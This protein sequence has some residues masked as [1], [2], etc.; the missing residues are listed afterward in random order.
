MKLIC[1][2]YAGAHVNVF[3]DLQRNLAE[4]HLE[5]EVLSLEYAGHGKRFSKKAFNSIHHNVSDLF[6]QLCQTIDKSEE[7]VLLGYSMGSIIAYE[8]AQLLMEQ[9]FN[10]K[11]LVFMAATPPHKI[12]VL[13]EDISEDE[14]LLQ[15][16]QIYGLIKGNQFESKEMRALFLPALRSDIQSVNDYNLVNDYQYITFDSS[17]DIA[18]FQGKEDISVTSL[19][20]WS[21]LSEKDITLYIYPS[22]HFF[23]Y[24][25]QQDVLN[26]LV[27]FITNNQECAISH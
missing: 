19:S 5:V 3:A 1:F 9:G 20:Y 16:C 22:G 24:D 11:K 10:V 14:A 18:V 8:M 27:C 6:T 17:V 21:D 25:Y 13:Q 4:R 26:D 2:P 7:L 23:Y 15:K 12:E